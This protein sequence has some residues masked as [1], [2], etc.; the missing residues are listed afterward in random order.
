M[1]ASDCRQWRLSNHASIRVFVVVVVVVYV[2][3]VGLVL[4]F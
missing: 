2:S 3:G 4:P 1:L